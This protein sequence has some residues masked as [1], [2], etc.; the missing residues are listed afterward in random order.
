MCW[1]ISHIVTN[2]FLMN[3]ETAKDHLSV[4]GRGMKQLKVLSHS[5]SKTSVTQMVVFYWLLTAWITEFENFNCAS[6]FLGSNPFC[7]LHS[8][9]P[10]FFFWGGGGA[11]EG[12]GA[13]SS[14]IWYLTLSSPAELRL[15]WL[16][17]DCSQSSTWQ[18]YTYILWK[19]LEPRRLDNSLFT[20]ETQR[21]IRY[22]MFYILSI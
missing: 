14:M 18:I 17:R 1:W 12:G 15:D 19:M 2:N 9:F 22:S 16:K 7:Q 4:F 11:S 13:S 20:K 6:R 8:V 10:Y 3:L 5:M 21:S